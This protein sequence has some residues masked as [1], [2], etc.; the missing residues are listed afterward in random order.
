MARNILGNIAVIFATGVFAGAGVARGASLPDT[1]GG[2]AHMVI[3]VRPAKTLDAGDLKVA[4]DHRPAQVVRLERLAG[5]L[6]DMQLFI[7][8]DDSTRSASLSVHL[9]ELKRFIEALPASTQVAVGYMRNGGFQLAQGFTAD[10]EKAASAL[11]LPLG[12]PGENGTPYFSLSYLVKHW[13]SKE[14][15]DRK[16]VLMLTDGVDRYW[17]TADPDDPYVNAAIEDTLKS[18]VELYSIYLRGA[19][20]YGRSGWQRTVAQGHL[21]EASEETGGTAYF[22]GFS[23]PVTISPFLKDFE[24]RLENQ[25]RVTITA[26]AKGVEGVKV[27]TEVPGVK[28]EA[29]TRVYVK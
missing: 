2:T 1:A 12:V 7:Y 17:G 22:Q 24:G 19:G 23:N 3:T 18:G 14:A 26:N 10:H 13:P 21:I 4:V 15:T 16:A 5:N 28:V 8:L 25:Y 20:L 11:R 9:G 29:P 6:A 27:M